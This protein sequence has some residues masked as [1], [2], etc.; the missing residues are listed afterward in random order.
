MILTDPGTVML[1][2]VRVATVTATAHAVGLNRNKTAAGVTAAGE[3]AALKMV[4]GFAINVKDKISGVVSIVFSV[5]RSGLRCA[6]LFLRTPALMALIRSLCTQAI[7]SLYPYPNPYLN[8]TSLPHLRYYT[9]SPPLFATS[10][11][12]HGFFFFKTKRV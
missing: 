1:R 2:T 12:F 8:V 3:I 11:E 4:I 6:A 7:F 10:M 5:A 9:P